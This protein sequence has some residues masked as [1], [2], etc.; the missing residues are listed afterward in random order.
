MIDKLLKVMRE[1][2]CVRNFKPDPVPEE[3]ID[4]ILEAGRLAPSGANTQPWEFLVVTDEILRKEIANVFIERR[5]A[6][7]KLD[8]FPFATSNNVKTAQAMIVVCGD[9]RFKEAYPYDSHQDGIY[10][11]GLASAIEHM[12]LAATAM[13]LGSCWCTVSPSVDRKLKKLLNVPPVY[14][15]FEIVL[16][17]FP[18]GETRGT[19]RRE[20]EYIVHRNRFEASKCRSE[21]EIR[22]VCDHQRPSGDV[23]SAGRRFQAES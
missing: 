6:C 11:M 23:Y 17:G 16:V 20:L 10:I 4:N 3:Y 8:D 7:K 2:N 12:H 1:R 14:D 18:K 13:G 9:P 22:K 15:I 21:E 5:E 19:A